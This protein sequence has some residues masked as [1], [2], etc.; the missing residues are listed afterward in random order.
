MGRPSKFDASFMAKVAIEALQEK[1]TLQALA[2]KY[3]VAPSKIEEWKEKLLQNSNKA[4]ESDAEDKRE[5]K[6]LK[7]TNAKLERK[8]GQLTLECDF[9]CG[10]L[11][12]CRTQ[13]QIAELEKKRPAGISRNRFC[14]LMDISRSGLYYEPA[15]ESKEN[16]EIMKIMDMYFMDH[17]TPTTGKR[18]VSNTLM[19][20][21]FCRNMSSYMGLQR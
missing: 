1:E 8:V 6:K 7:E 19:F 14:Q 12:G 17:P 11:R 13:S 3:G 16:Q 18:G 10:S 20:T 4:F 9:F 15:E 5:I 21:N 2:K